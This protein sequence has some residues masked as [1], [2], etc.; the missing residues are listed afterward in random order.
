MKIK[1]KR[2]KFSFTIKMLLSPH[3]LLFCPQSSHRSLVF[4]MGSQNRS[5]QPIYLTK[6]RQLIPPL[7]PPPYCS[8]CFATG[9][10]EGLF[11]PFISSVFEF[12]FVIFYFAKFR[13]TKFRF[14][15]SNYK[16]FD[17]NKQINN[18]SFQHTRFIYLFISIIF[19]YV[20]CTKLLL[21]PSFSEDIFSKG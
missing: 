16:T 21:N 3:Q 10:E 11:C 18:T 17:L 6:E 20:S 13:G 19:C 4:Y 7:R 12:Y 8:W 2:I 9:G 15:P 14:T 5:T 1:S